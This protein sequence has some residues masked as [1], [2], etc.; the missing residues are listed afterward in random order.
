MHRPVI[1]I[2]VGD[3]C[4]IGPEITAKALA[5][6]EIYTNSRPLVIADA[7]LMQE[8]IRIAGV[9]LGV[10]VVTNPGEGQYQV[11]TLDVLDMKNIDLSQ[12]EYGKV[13]HLG[14]EASFQYV[15]KAIELAL[16]GEVDGTTTGPIHK[17]AINLAGHHY[18]GHTEIFAQLTN[19]KDYCMML[20]DKDFRV[21]HVTTHVAL[22]QV[23]AL[24]KKE[25]V[26]KVIDLTHK[27]LVKMGIPNP[28][29]GV[30]GLNPHAGDGGLFGREE[31]EEIKPAIIQAREQGIQVDG[32][33]SPDTIFVKLSGGQYD[34]LVA[35]YHDQG[36]IPTKLIGFKYDNNTKEWG[37]VA[38]IN[39]TLGL[40]II[41]TSVDHGV[42]FDQAGKGKAN[43][44]SM[45]DALKL[46]AALS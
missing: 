20:L 44:E 3:P 1:A 15:V 38:G 4:G 11:G 28:R 42:A 25:R 24:V 34:A 26:L 2:S 35:M 9:N 41:R 7:G 10:R 14:G 46:A 45:V 18:A 6:P 37:S 13:T 32:P 40:P 30:A 43:P 36:H 21:S 8:A 27:A 5:L 16:A 22:N 12:L 33:I 19:T 31:I 17:E 23:S 39:I 29:L